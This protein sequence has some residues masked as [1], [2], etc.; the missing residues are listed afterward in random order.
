V[1]AQVAQIRSAGIDVPVLTLSNVTRDGMPELQGVLESG[2]TYC[3]VGSSGVGKSTLINALLGHER[4]R[5][6]AVRERDSRGRHTTTNRELVALPQGA[7]LIDTPG[8]REL[9]LWESEAALEEAFEDIDALADGCFFRDCQHD[10]EP[11]C[12]VK[13][14]VVSGHL[15]PERLANFHRLRREA[16]HLEAK[17]DERAASE[18][19][20]KLKV[21]HHNIR[22][23]TSKRI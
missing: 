12:A 14:A 22:R 4:L 2:K 10:T 19:K 8:M 17:V 7:L 15:P 6:R 16:K 3:F 20:R 5:T 9:Q 21:L 11:R 23:F 13:A 1:A 18:E